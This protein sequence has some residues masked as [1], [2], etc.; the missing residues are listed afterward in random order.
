MKKN[1]KQE[2]FRKNG[3]TQKDIADASGRSAPMVCRVLRYGERSRF[4]ENAAIS[5]PQE[6]VG[7]ENCPSRE[8]VFGHGRR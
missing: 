6:K 5:L 1:E 4:I 2:I 7:H 8:E 3:I